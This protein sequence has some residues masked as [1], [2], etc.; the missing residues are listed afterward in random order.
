MDNSHVATY[1]RYGRE[2]STRADT[3][4]V[5]GRINEPDMPLSSPTAQE[6]SS[7]NRLQA[8]TSGRMSGRTQVWL[9]LAVMLAIFPCGGATCSKYRKQTPDFIPPER[10]PA[11]P[12]LEQLITQLNRVSAIERLSSLRV[13]LSTPGTSMKLSGNLS[14]HRPSDF[15]LQ[16]YPGTRMMGDAL[17]AG[18]N[19]E[20]FWLM[21]KLPGESPMLY[22][23]S[24]QQFEMQPGPRRVL[25]VSPLWIREALGI[26]EFEPGGHHEG[27][28]ERSADNL[29]E[30]RS[31]IPTH[32]G[33]YK[34]TVVVEPKRATVRQVILKDPEDRM[35]ASATLSEHQLYTAIDACLP[36][37]VD[38]Q[39][40]PD[41]GMQPEMGQVLAF[42][43]EID[44][45]TINDNS[46][47]E[48][49]R[50]TMPESGGYQ[51]VDLVQLNANLAQPAPPISS[52]PHTA[53]NPYAP[54]FR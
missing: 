10:F 41:A 39:M 17:D 29:V 30:I 48:A 24:H 11:P 22:Y 26:I 52:P 42:T 18:S 38:L 12:T 6:H 46:G 50:Y 27:P 8:M 15:R 3:I 54:V 53:T 9:M 7:D 5:H 14:W 43:I 47:N 2:Y 23:A 40:Q 34:R 32:R 25:P 44:N 28:I 31:I 45:F 1:G 19:A 51:T 36:H 33:S 20:N 37:R 16:A 35:V 4:V 49:Q 13:T 21:T